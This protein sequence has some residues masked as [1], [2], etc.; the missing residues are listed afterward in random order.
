[1]ER[2]WSLSLPAES[3]LTDSR[4]LLLEL[5]LEVR[6]WGASSLAISSWEHATLS[7]KPMLREHVTSRMM[8]ASER[9]LGDCE[10]SCRRQLPECRCL[11]ALLS[12]RLGF[13]IVPW[14]LETERSLAGCILTV[15]LGVVRTLSHSVRTL[16]TEDAAHEARCLSEAA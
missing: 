7:W 12:S 16:L 5:W 10:M 6:W 1:M 4:L 8:V 9:A 13:F 2:M 11:V 3:W 14:K 15:D